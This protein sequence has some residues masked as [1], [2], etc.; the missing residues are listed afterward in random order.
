MRR[1][2]AAATAL[3]AL[4]CAAA[5]SGS[6][7]APTPRTG[8]TVPAAD[9]SA[10]VRASADAALSGNTKAICDQVARTGTA[11]G[12]TYLADLKLQADAA[13]QGSQAKAEARQKLA[14]DVSN[15]SYA[16]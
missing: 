1:H 11:F 9:P 2:L 10:S 13:S 6:A 8:P 16:L 4:L 12:T 14:R 5:C 15:Y 7:D 3:A